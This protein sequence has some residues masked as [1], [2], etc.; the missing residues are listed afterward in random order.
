MSK[1]PR[2][3]A[4]LSADERT[5]LMIGLDQG[6]SR[7]AI[8]RLLKRAPSTICREMRRNQAILPP[9]RFRQGNH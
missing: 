2:E 5:A 7:R 8:A 4:Q 9:K 3:Y 6:L 1:E